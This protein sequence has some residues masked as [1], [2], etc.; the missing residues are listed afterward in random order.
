VNKGKKTNSTIFQRYVSL[1][2]IYKIA[3]QIQKVDEMSYV[4]LQSENKYNSQ[5][6][7]K[8]REIK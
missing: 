8:E 5:I 4:E 1:C 6:K 7:D 2:E 3:P